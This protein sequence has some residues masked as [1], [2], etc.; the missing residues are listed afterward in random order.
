MKS[1][2][3]HAGPFVG[4]SLWRVGPGQATELAAVCAA[5][6]TGAPTSITAF[7]TKARNAS[8]F[9]IANM[10]NWLPP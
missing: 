2:V 3:G 4:A 5:S 10:L 7:L 1:F 9:A 6:E 8:T